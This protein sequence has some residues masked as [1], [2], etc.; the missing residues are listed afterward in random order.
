LTEID[1]L[2]REKEALEL[3]YGPWTAHNLRLADGLYTIGPTPAGDEIKLRRIV[4]IASDLSGGDVEGLRIL[5]LACLEGMYALEFARRGATVVAIEGREANIEKA[6]FAARV[7]GL[8]VDFQLGDVRELSRE[9][10]GDFDIVLCLGILYHL[11]ADDVAAMVKE[12]RAVTRNVAIFDTSVARARGETRRFGDLV[13]HGEVIVEHTPGSTPEQRLERVWASLDNPRAF[14]P[15][16]PSLLRLLRHSGFPTVLQAHV[17][18]EP[19]QPRGRVTLVALSRQEVQPLL[20]PEPPVDDVP[21]GHL[22]R[23]RPGSWHAH[24]PPPLRR[25]AKRLRR[26]TS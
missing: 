18:V 2:R 6:R 10:H 9:R 8:D 4:Q 7:L 19:R 16:L 22:P 26:A 23:R 12:I 21:E 24:V 1:A 15:S 25:A 17:P 14:L 3:H 11:D 5:D 20:V 13:L